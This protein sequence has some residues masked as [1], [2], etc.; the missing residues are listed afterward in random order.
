MLAT[1]E[2][3]QSPSLT[4]STAGANVKFRSRP[5]ARREN[6]RW[7]QSL[8]PGASVAVIARNNGINANLLLK[9]RRAHGRKT[10]ATSLSTAAAAAPTVL[11]PVHVEP[12]TTVGARSALEPTGRTHRQGVPEVGIELSHHPDRSRIWAGVPDVRAA[13][14]HT[15]RSSSMVENQNSRL[16]RYFF[17]RRHLGNAYLSLLQ[18]FLNHRVLMRSRRAERVGKTPS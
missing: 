18:F 11:L 14:G 6:R 4:S 1:F 9:W 13:M 8:Q 10:T 16:R 15:P 3:P 7:L 2:R 5:V 12:V 17:L